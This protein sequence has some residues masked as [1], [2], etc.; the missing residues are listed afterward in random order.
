MLHTEITPSNVA[1]YRLASL[2]DQQLAE[3]TEARGCLATF[4][5]RLPVFESNTDAPSSCGMT[6][7]CEF[8][9]T[10]RRLGG[11]PARM[12]RREFFRLLLMSQIFTCLSAPPDTIISPSGLKTAVK[13]DSEWACGTSTTMCCTLMSQILKAPS[14]EEITAMGLDGCAEMLVGLHLSPLPPVST[15]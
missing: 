8:G 13:H 4:P 3:R 10:L 7:L 2:Y 1:V 5:M 15:C 9:D 6:M 14:V 11:A 12:S